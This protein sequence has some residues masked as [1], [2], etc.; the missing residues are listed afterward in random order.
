MISTPWSHERMRPCIE[1]KRQRAGGV[2]FHGKAPVD[3]PG[4]DAQ[5]GAARHQPARKGA[6]AAADAERRLVDLREANEHLVLAALTAR[7]LQTAAERARQR[8]TAFLA[9][10]ADE[11]RNPMAPI[12]IAAAML[13]GLPT[14][15]RLL[16]RVQGLVEQQMTQ[17][18]RLVGELVD[19]SAVDTGG[20]GARPPPGRHGPGHRR[21]RC[22]LPTG[23][24]RTRPAVRVPPATRCAPGAG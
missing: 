21:G 5:P 20:I 4:L 1:T 8:H 18:S 9:A 24:G 14:D 19:A 23:D 22:G 12:R 15:E 3:G 10:V 17:M 13:G 16:P 11:L 2:A 7:E 6:G